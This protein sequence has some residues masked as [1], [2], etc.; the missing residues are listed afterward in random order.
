MK[1]AICLLLICLFLAVPV[2]CSGTPEKQL[3]RKTYFDLF[4]TVCTVSGYAET[5]EAFDAVA[6]QV[7]Q[8]L[9]SCHRMCDIYYP[10]S[11]LVNLYTLNREAAKAPVQVSTELMDFLLQCK[12][13]MTLTGGQTN[14]AMGAVLSLWHDCREEAL[15]DPSSARLP[16]PDAL[17]AAGEHCDPDD[18]ILDPDAGTVYFAD[19]LLQLDVGAVAKG[20]AAERAAGWLEDNGYTGYSLNLGGNLRV[21]G[22]KGDGEAWRVGITDPRDEG[23]YLARLALT[24]DSLV[25]SG[26][27]QRYF[28]VDGVTYHHIIDPD[29]LYPAQWFVSVS[30]VTENSGLGDALSTA[31]FNLSLADGQALVERLGGVEALWLCE[32]GMI[33]TSSGFD[34]LRLP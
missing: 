12:E 25:T 7:Y 18:L 32:D 23:A 1:K 22:P 16:D 27:Y 4:D 8:V 14:I 21:V 3:Y 2:S 11:G 9:L 19:P 17:A 34:S 20:Y 6:Q 15:S 30:V 33:Y 24:D 5:E 13:Y 26:S 31:L 29:T 10:Y 28:T